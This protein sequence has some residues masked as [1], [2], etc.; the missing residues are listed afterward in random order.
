MKKRIN[1]SSAI[2]L[3]KSHESWLYIVA[4]LLAISGLCWLIAHYFLLTTNEF[5]DTHHPSELWWLRLHGAAA[6]GFLIIFGSLLPVHISQAW[7]M[8]KNRVTGAVMFTIVLLLI[9]TAYGLYYSGSDAMRAWLSATHCIVGIV[10][11]GGL[12]AHVWMGK[13]RQR[14]P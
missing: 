5:G 2:R 7:R 11:I 3:Q 13:Y 14:R 12:A 4:G 9:T 1:Q 10:A 6:M 8:R